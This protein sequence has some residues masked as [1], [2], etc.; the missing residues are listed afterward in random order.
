MSN[1]QRELFKG[2]SRTAKSKLGGS[3]HELH[4]IAQIEIQ[5]L[6]RQN[7]KYAELLS[8]LEYRINKYSIH[9]LEDIIE[10]WDVDAEA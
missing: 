3:F 7:E 8:E 2:S 5:K 4:M 9:S 6:E 1:F 10:G